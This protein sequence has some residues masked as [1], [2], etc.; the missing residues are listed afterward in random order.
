MAGENENVLELIAYLKS[1]GFEGEKLEADIRQG[2]R[3]SGASFTVHHRIAFGD[4]MMRYDLRFVHDRQFMAYRLESYEASHRLPVTIDHGVVNG[5]DT[6]ALEERMAGI[7]WV[8]HFEGTTAGNGPDDVSEGVESDLWQLNAKP[9][10]D[11]EDIQSRLMF[12]YWPESH[13]DD[14]VKELRPALERSRTFQAA[15][16]GI[17]GAVLAYNIVSGHLD[18]L[19]EL[20]KKTGIEKYPGIDL[21]GLLAANLSHDT[22]GFEISCS[23]GEEEGIVDFR[24]PIEKIDGGYHADTN[25]ATFTAYP[26]IQHGV[27][28]GINTRD[29]EEQMKLI[30]WKADDGLYQFNEHEDVVLLPHVQAIKDSIVRL[31]GHERTKDIADYLQ[32]KYWSD[33]FMEIYVEDETWQMKA[34]DSV[35]QRFR[36]SEDTKTISN[37]LRGGPV[38]ATELKTF[39]HGTDGW[40]IIDPSTVSA[41][42]LNTMELVK[43]L[44]RQQAETMVNMLPLDGTVYVGDIVRSIMQ[45][46]QVP[47]DLIGVDGSLRVNVKAN[48]R[49][50]RLEL[51]TPDDRPIP[52]NFRL[53]PAWTPEPLI[54]QQETIR[55]DTKAKKILDKRVKGIGRSRKM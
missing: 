33:S 2:Y 8:R 35:K 25:H 31:A 16:R 19:Y 22:D 14:L 53:D 51:Q 13:W 55:E 50:S 18:S 48:P 1:L 15:E 43:G 23:V 45:G 54:A 39:G 32:V 29:L 7:D 12:K 3:E 46:E 4:E 20:I 6:R 21:E 42:G 9:S 17:C 40:F 11:A 49:E 5:I 41:D 30:D 36:L 28:D 37:L 10:F 44:T 34:W 47:V 24:I 52:F 38:H 27:F 26:E